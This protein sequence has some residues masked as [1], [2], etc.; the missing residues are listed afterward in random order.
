MLSGKDSTG[1]SE[2]QPA[3]RITHTVSSPARVGLFEPASGLWITG[4]LSNGIIDFTRQPERS[5]SRDPYMRQE[6]A[7]HQLLASKDNGHSTWVAG[8]MT[9]GRTTER[10]WNTTTCHYASANHPTTLRPSHL[11]AV[12]INAVKAMTVSHSQGKST[13]CTETPGKAG[14]NVTRRLNTS[15]RNGRPVYNSQ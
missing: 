9:G 3:F 15:M 6:S 1:R 8:M 10:S 11:G 2:R 5:R 13:H 4:V 12:T 7:G 14:H